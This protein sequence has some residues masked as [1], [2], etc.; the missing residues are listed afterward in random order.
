MPKISTQPQHNGIALIVEDEVTNRMILKALLKKHGYN[1][2]EAENGAEAIQHFKKQ[3]P[4]IIF[5]DVMMPVMD[6][7]EAASEIKRLAGDQFVPIIFLTAMSDE[8][9]LARCVEVGG[10]DFLSKPYSFTVLSAKV[11]A[12][13]RIRTLHRDTRML[14]SRMQ[15]DEE[16]AEQVF[17]GAVIAGNVALEHIRSLL[18]PASVF[19]GDL[20]LTA[21]APSHDLHV[22]LG[23]FT[24]HGLA[25]ALGALPTSE[26][27]RSMTAK[28]FAPQQI[29]FAINN[30]LHDL[31]PTGMFLAAQFV[32]IDHQLDH[33]SIINCGMPDCYL[34]ENES[35]RLKYEIASKSLPLGIAPD[36]DFRDDFHHLRV[37]EGDRV[38]LATDGVTE[39]RDLNGELFGQKRFIEAIRKSDSSS[40]IMDKLAKDLEAFC[41]DAPQDDD[42]SVV[43]VPLIRELLP[44]WESGSHHFVTDGDMPQNLFSHEQPDCI[45]FQLILYGSQLRQADPVPILINYIQETAGLHEHRRPLFTILTELYINALDHGVLQLDSMLKQGEDGFTNYFQ[46]REQRLEALTKGQIRIGLRIHQNNNSG[47]IVITVE[48]SGH[49]FEFKTLSQHVT[50]ETLYSGRGIMLVKSLVKQLQFFEPGNKAEAI[51]VWEDKL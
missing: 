27:F 24:G 10:D 46:Q 17:S 16:I 21:F 43:E 11:K 34:I 14:Y 30:K 4:D 51:Y 39:A 28:G 22:L 37:D 38:I 12:M 5:M 35:M 8:K 26:A 47:Y 13:E 19:S 1:V 32:K 45:E 6:G 31:L 48:D 41:Q 7:Y 49:G 15:R 23:D 20:M 9:A 3:S 40:Y 33:I 25:A 2:I 29:L 18:K 36:I 42:I 44:G 50:N